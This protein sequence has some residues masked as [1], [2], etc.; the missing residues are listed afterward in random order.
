M[1]KHDIKFMSDDSATVNGKI[2]Y[3]DS[4]DNWNS[5]IGMTDDEKVAFNN[6]LNKR[7]SKAS[8]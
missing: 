8:D 1:S 7:N 2:A 6:A 3:K 4:N 5:Q